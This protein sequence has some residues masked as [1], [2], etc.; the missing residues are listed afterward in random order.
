MISI[1]HIFKIISKPSAVTVGPMKAFRVL[2][3][4]LAQQGLI[5]QTLSA[6]YLKFRGLPSSPA[7]AT[8]LFM[9]SLV[10]LEGSLLEEIDLSAMLSGLRIQV[11][12]K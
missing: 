1:S 5:A 12:V 4:C 6:L 11:R 8:A 3:E 7:K 2:A 10:G 9:R